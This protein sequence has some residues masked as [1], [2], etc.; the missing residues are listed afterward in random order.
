MLERVSAAA[1]IGTL[2]T[3]VREYPVPAAPPDGEV[4]RV[5]A[6]GVSGSDWQVCQVDR[7]RRIMYHEIV[8]RIYRV[9]PTA[10]RMSN[11]LAGMLTLRPCL[12]HSYE[13]VKLALRFIVS[14]HFPLDLMTTHRFG[15]ANGDVAMRPVGGQGASG[16]V[17]VTALPWN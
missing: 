12:G 4:L 1:T 3:E 17:R 13:S 5:E 14:G 10:R 2:K 7:P 8:G 6:A 11:L 16:A 15:L 9:G